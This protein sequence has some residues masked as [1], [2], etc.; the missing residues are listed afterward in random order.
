MGHINTFMDENKPKN[1]PTDR[2]KF[3]IVVKVINI[4]EI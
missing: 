1:H 3:S 4:V 2:M